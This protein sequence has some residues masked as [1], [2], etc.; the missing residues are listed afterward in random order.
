MNNKVCSKKRSCA[1][2]PA[3]VLDG[4]SSPTVFVN[5]TMEYYLRKKGLTV[6][7]MIALAC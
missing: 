7:G 4:Q 5:I 6:N 2:N 3:K 1:T